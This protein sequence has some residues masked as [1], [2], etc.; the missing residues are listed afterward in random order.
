MLR[1]KGETV[2]SMERHPRVEG[3]G[4]EGSPDMEER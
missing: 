1:S 4:L 2:C 3:G